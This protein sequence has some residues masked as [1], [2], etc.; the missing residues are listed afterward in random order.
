MITNLQ[1]VKLV[2]SKV[3]TNRFDLSRSFT[4]IQGQMKVKEGSLLGL[5]FG[6]KTLVTPRAKTQ[7]LAIN[8]K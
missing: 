3:V 8:T 2:T 4:V 5:R 6:A 7:L 1:L